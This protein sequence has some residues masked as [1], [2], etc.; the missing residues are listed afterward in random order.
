M[1]MR[2]VVMSAALVCVGVLPGAT[3]A[4]GHECAQGPFAKAEVHIIDHNE[5]ATNGIEFA[6][7]GNIQVGT[8]TSNYAAN[9]NMEWSISASTNI[10]I[11]STR[12]NAEKDFDFVI[13]M[14]CC[15][16]WHRRL[17]QSLAMEWS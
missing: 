15:D 5:A 1:N 10:N 11:S 6:F 7:A 17:Q 9:S 3:F 12:F 14:P 16:E 8:A 2:S 4:Q 13:W